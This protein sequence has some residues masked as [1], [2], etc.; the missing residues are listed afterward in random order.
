MVAQP[1]VEPQIEAGRR[2]VEFLDSHG[3]RPEAAFWLFSSDFDD[4]RLMLAVKEVD[5][6]GPRRAYEK[7][8][9]LE[10]G[11]SINEVSLV[12][13]KNAMVKRLRS[14]IRTGKGIAAIRLTGNVIDGTYV[15]DALI[16]R[17]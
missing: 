6:G 14:A 13:P 15:E 2:L 7:F 10:T 4:W 1:L 11:V 3:M 8:L 9:N 12:S 17:L 16:Y 5:E